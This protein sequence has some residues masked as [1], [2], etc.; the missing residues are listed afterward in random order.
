MTGSLM[1]SDGSE[2]A[3]TGQ[4]IDQDWSALVRFDGD[5]VAEFHEFYDQLT[6][7]VQ[8]GLISP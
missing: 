6:L 2:V 3:A 8:L 5:H 1:L 4:S 7:M